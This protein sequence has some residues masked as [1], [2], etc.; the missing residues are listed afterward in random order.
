[1]GECIASKLCHSDWSGVCTFHCKTD[2]IDQNLRS[3]RTVI[4]AVITAKTG[5]RHVHTS[6]FITHLI[7]RL[8]S[9]LAEVEEAYIS[10]QSAVIVERQARHWQVNARVASQ[11]LGCVLCLARL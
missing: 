6:Q 4:N 3:P 2:Y 7:F 1:M 9:L 5:Y 10:L 8:L 11:A